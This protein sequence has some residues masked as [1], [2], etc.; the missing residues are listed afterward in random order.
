M[1]EPGVPPLTV[2][3]LAGV[4]DDMIVIGPADPRTV[5]HH[6]GCPGSEQPFDALGCRCGAIGRH[7]AVI[8]RES[9]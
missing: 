1:T 8:R 2:V 3:A 7:Y 4:P 5:P 9:A 6:S